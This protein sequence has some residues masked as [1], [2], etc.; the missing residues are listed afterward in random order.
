MSEI[1][2]S[3]SGDRLAAFRDALRQSGIRCRSQQIRMQQFFAAVPVR[4]WK[5]VCALAE[6]YAV[7]LKIR[8]QHGLRFRLLPYRFRIGLPAG[9]LLGG[10]FLYWCN[11]SVRSIEIYGNT[12]V[13][14]TEILTALETLG[15][16]QG[17]PFREIPYTYIE[18]QMRLAVSDIEWITIRHEGGRLLVDLTEETKP[19]AL[20]NDRIP[21]NYIATV[22]SQITKMDI[23][24]GKAMKSV[25]D[26]VKPGDLL[27]SGTEEDK[28]GVCRYYHADG[29]VTGIYPDSFT[30]MQP[31]VA[32]LPVRGETITNTVLSVFG[33]RIPLTLGFVP[34]RR[35]ES[36]I[37]EEDREPLMLLGRALP[38]TLLHCRYTR[39][40]SAITV[41]SADEA[42]AALEEAAARYELNLHADDTIISKKAKFQQTDLGILLN[43]NYVFEGVIGKTSEIFVKLS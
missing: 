27:I 19:P 12:R 6:Q 5:P 1:R 32:E 37:Y 15:V 7:T 40:T 35:T 42:R 9:L 14:D 29:T 3:A 24:G 28:F 4:S 22:P 38:L 23:C 16:M 39:Q 36:I 20:T 21:T 33:Q 31:F 17:V 2:F 25:G 10:L 26:L 43:I 34:P 13:S 11:A 41:F 18:Q 30:Q 8:S